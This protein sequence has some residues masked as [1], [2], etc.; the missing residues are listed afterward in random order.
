VISTVVRGK[1]LPTRQR[2]L[3]SG[4]RS[5]RNAIPAAGD[6]SDKNSD[7]IAQQSHSDHPVI[8]TVS[9]SS[10]IPDPIPT[11]FH[12]KHFV[13]LALFLFLFRLNEK[14]PGLSSSTC[15]VRKRRNDS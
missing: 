11:A 4:H 5:K 8:Q 1:V 3:P 2:S 6:G 13:F 10:S 9:S 15:C 7:L 12:G 14:T